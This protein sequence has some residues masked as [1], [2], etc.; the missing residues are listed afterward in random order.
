MVTGLLLAAGGLIAA[1]CSSEDRTPGA[2]NGMLLP[3]A[4]GTDIQQPSAGGT[5]GSAGDG[6]TASNG[7]TGTG[8][9]EGQSVNLP[10]AGGA[11]AGG[12]PGNGNGG[13]GGAPTVD[14]MLPSANCAA[15]EGAVPTLAL[16]EVSGDLDRPLFVTGVPGDDSRLF[17]MEKGGTVRVILDGQLQEQPFVDVS[18]QIDENGTNERGLL[19]MA[20]HP[21]YAS[22]GLFYLHF[23]S[24]GQNG[25]PVG[26]GVVVE[27]AV[28]PNNPSLANP[29]SQRQ[30]LVVNQPEPNHNGG[31][32]TFGPDGFLYLGFGDGG[33]G[34][35]AH[36][37]IGNGQALD[38]LL[39]K[40]LRIDPLGRG[41]DDA[42]SIPPG[43]FTAPNARAEIWAYG[44]RNPWRFSF[45]P[46]G[47]AL[48]VGDVGQNAVEEIDFLPAGTAAGTN[49]GWRI[50]EGPACRPGEPAGNC[51]AATAL[52]PPVDSYSQDPQASVTGG[53][54]YRG[55]GIAG[56]RG[57]YIYADYVTARFFRFR[58]GENGQATDRQEITNQLRPNGG[59][60]QQ[61]SSFGQDNAGDVYVT[62]FNPGAIYRITAA[63]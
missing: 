63:P 40:L 46:C 22:N 9:T 4:G 48:Y 51:T 15:P 10:I 27:L 14:P 45:D 12:N 44:L 21:S 55:S 25:I 53:Y 24:A 30:L 19:G 47:G 42:Y 59:A 26:A 56:L 37:T 41:V 11:N 2:D 3:G 35:D 62:A 8:G 18:E 57:T 17:V 54:V 31:M 6:Q 16:T 20:F 29:D 49:F 23:S 61:I 13:G 33:G 60:P 32:I 58:M 39:G 1:A 43:N 38:T 7:G 52:T 36:G 50:M 5:N 28:D 34:N